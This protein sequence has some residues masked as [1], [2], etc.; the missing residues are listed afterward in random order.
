MQ[1]VI[2]GIAICV[3]AVVSWAYAARAD[4]TASAYTDGRGIN[5]RA[6]VR[7]RA[8]GHVQRG[9]QQCTYVPLANP[10]GGVA[11]MP[12]SIGGGVLAYTLTPSAAQRDGTWYAKWCGIANFAGVF[13]VRRV[14]PRALAEEAQRYL[15]LPL[16]TPRMSPAGD[17]IVNLPTWLWLAGNW[18]SRSSTV[19]VPGVSVTVRAV[20]EAVVWT[21]GDGGRITCD[22]PGTPY[23]TGLADT[24][25]SPTC[26]YTYRHSSATQAGLRYQAAVT[27]RWH[28]AWA[29]S[30]TVGGGTLGT[31]ERTT[32]LGIR[33]GELQAINT[34]AG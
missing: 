26:G 25:Q 31:I 23:R 3:V 19:S 5:E 11:Y 16:P 2:A 8:V 12:L 32:T 24:A 1:R 13:F 10:N 30:G 22:G 14:S 20:P 15:A 21:M 9:I 17:Q 29:A 6:S 27:V 33:V 28:A 4:T 7:R 34:S 18:Q